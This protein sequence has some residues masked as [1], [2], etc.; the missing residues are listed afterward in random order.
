ML[1]NNNSKK[2]NINIRLANMSD[3]RP[4]YEAKKESISGLNPIE[5]ASQWND[6]L[7]DLLYAKLITSKVDQVINQIP[8]PIRNAANAGLNVFA[9]FATNIEEF[10]RF[11]QLNSASQHRTEKGAKIIHD[12][13]IKDLNNSS[14]LISVLSFSGAITGS[15]AAVLTP[16]VAFTL[17]AGAWGVAGFAAAHLNRAIKKYQDPVFWVESSLNKY[18]KT[19]D[20]ITHHKTQINEL[21]IEQ[22]QSTDN[23]KKNKL[24]LEIKKIKQKIR[25]LKTSN[26]NLKEKAIAIAQVKLTEDKPLSEKSK[27]RLTNLIFGN[28]LKKMQDTLASKP[29]TETINFVKELEKNQREVIISRTVATIGLFTVATGMTLIAI[30][31]FTGPFAPA[32]M[33]A[34]L[35]VSGLGT[36]I[37]IGQSLANRIVNSVAKNHQYKVERAQFLESYTKDG[38]LSHHELASLTDKEKLQF[39]FSFE[40]SQGF[41][42]KEQTHNKNPE[43]VQTLWY[44]SLKALDAKDRNKILKAAQA[45]TFDDAI[46]ART[47]G[48]DQNHKLISE[49]AKQQIISRVSRSNFRVSLISKVDSLF[50]K[51]LAPEVELPTFKAR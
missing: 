5:V 2:L 37:Q 14:K 39:R 35:V 24:D 49:K 6:K 4:K 10:K 45:K 26:L 40:H 15:A 44:Q 27:A 21:L 3:T 46:L 22:N 34:G 29:T 50:Q 17:T 31:P 20:K 8:E 48:V 51:K 47:L 19:L 33:A 30:S 9:G 12:A 42:S 38:L 28:D 18:E 1:K 7:S 32:V 36:A 16:L 25:T 43:E 11:R 41:I 13:V 23:L